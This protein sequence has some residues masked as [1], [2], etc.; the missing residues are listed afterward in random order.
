MTTTTPHRRRASGGTKTMNTDA[1]ERIANALERIAAALEPSA[2]DAWG[3][4][5]DHV[6]RIYFL[7]SHEDSNRALARIADAVGDLSDAVSEGKA[8]TQTLSAML[9]SG[10]VDASSEDE[11]IAALSRSEKIFSAILEDIAGAVNTELR[12]F[13]GMRLRAEEELDPDE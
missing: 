2:K 7:L 4:F 9:A 1:T 10:R 12:G 8:V 13:R 11:V 5:F 6:A 3:N